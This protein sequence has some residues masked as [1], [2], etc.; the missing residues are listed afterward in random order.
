MKSAQLWQKMCPDLLSTKKE[1][2]FGPSKCAL[3]DS[4]DSIAGHW[5][6]KY[7]DFRIG[8]A[9]DFVTRTVW[10]LIEDSSRRVLRVE[11]Y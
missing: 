11:L 4:S 3:V 5:R 7:V 9:I 8:S 6:Q 10:P 1:C 2:A